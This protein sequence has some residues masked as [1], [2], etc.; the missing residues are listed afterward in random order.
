MVG[1]LKKIL[2]QKIQQTTKTGQT[3]KKMSLREDKIKNNLPPSCSQTRC[4]TSKHNKT[5]EQNQEGKVSSKIRSKKRGEQTKEVKGIDKKWMASLRWTRPKASRKIRNKIKS[6]DR[7][8]NIK[9]RWSLKDLN[10]RIKN[11]Q[12]ILA[13]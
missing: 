12:K 5:K 2:L 8:T 9:S 13:S 10:S 4:R 1:I 7:T 11:L 6:R 3:L